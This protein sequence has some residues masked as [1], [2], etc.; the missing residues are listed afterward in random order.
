MTQPA[1][2]ITGGARRIGAAIARA[3]GDAGWHVVIHYGSSR[4]EAEALAGE[5]P[6]AETASCD[7]ADGEASVALVERL[8]ARLDDWRV[9]V[10]CAS[11]FEP[12]SSRALDPE[13]NRRAFAINAATP[14]RMAQAFLARSRRRSA[15]PTPTSSATP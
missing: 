8:A 11:V 7:L 5:L 15:I 1:V 12:D 10:N 6:S 14:A 3:F 9:L 4:E 2:L 13:T